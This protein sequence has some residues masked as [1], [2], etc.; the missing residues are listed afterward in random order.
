M[1]SLALVA[2]VPVS[3][4]KALRGGKLKKGCRYVKG[5]VM[6]TPEVASRLK[7]LKAKGHKKGR[8]GGRRGVWPIVAKTAQ[9]QANQAVFRALIFSRKEFKRARTCEAKRQAARQLH[10]VYGKLASMPKSAS[11][12]LSVQERNRRYHNSYAKVMHDLQSTCGGGGAAPVRFV[13]AVRVHGQPPA[14]YPRA[15]NGLSGKRRR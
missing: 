14:P 12:K 7:G 13:P 2:T 10:I 15:T 8:K 5:R 11:G 6:C 9:G 4:A 3:K 1:D